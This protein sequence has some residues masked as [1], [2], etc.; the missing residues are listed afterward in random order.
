MLARGPPTMASGPLSAKV[1]PQAWFRVVVL[2]LFTERNQI[3]H[4]DFVREPHYRNVLFHSRN[5][6]SVCVINETDWLKSLN[7]DFFSLKKCLRVFFESLWGKLCRTK[8]FRQVWGNSGKT[9]SHLKNLSAPTPM[10]CGYMWSLY[11]I[12]LPQ[13]RGS[14]HKDNRIAQDHRNG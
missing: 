7:L 5:L 9:P 12:Y 10:E 8:I 3:Q 4:Y 1:C 2:N 13:T 6:C 14:Y 11:F